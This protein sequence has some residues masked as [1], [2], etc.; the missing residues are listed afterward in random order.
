MIR[1]AIGDRIGTGVFF[2]IPEATRILRECAFEDI[3]YEHCSYFTPAS[4]ARLFTDN[5]FAVD[6]ISTEYDDQYLQIEAHAIDPATPQPAPEPETS[7]KELENLVRDFAERFEVKRRD[8]EERLGAYAQNKRKVVLW[9]ASSKS[10]AFLSLFAHYGVIEY[11]VDI[12]P[13]RQ[14]H[15]LPG[16]ALRIVG[17]EFLAT[18]QP[19]VVIIMNPIYREEI[20]SDLKS[21]GLDPE[22]VTM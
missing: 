18:Y 16:S 19:D 11:A 4:L 15:Y 12:N 3:F 9:G 6:A 17:P 21:M 20:A 14:N 5:G 13:Y 1:R 2:Q 22:I 10:V 7:V 8:W